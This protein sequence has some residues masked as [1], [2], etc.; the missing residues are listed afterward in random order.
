MKDYSGS[1]R[2]LP[3]DI[4]AVPWSVDDQRE[5]IAEFAEM[6]ARRPM[7]DNLGGMAFNHCFAVWFVLRTVKPP[8]V[9]ESGV[10]QGQGTWLIEQ[11]CPDSQIVCLD[12]TFDY[13]KWRS[14]KA[15]YIAQDFC[16]VD[17]SSYDL[18]AAIAI[19]D[20]HQNAYRRLKEMSWFGLRQAIFEDNFP[21]GEG[22]CYSPRHILAGVGHPHIQEFEAL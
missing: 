8:L 15:S 21:V 20:D 14:A 4:G 16:Q 1:D 7:P 6:Y 9:I 12:V 19:F 5:A 22:D 10:F 2:T 18:S 11:A 13:L 3:R 17:W